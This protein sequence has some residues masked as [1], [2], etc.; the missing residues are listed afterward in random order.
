MIVGPVN[1]IHALHFLKELCPCRTMSIA[2]P[3]D[4]LDDL[5]LP[6][7]IEESWQPNSVC[8]AWTPHSSK[9]SQDSDA[10]ICD[11]ILTE[12]N[13]S[14]SRNPSSLISVSS[15]GWVPTQECRGKEDRTDSETRKR[16]LTTRPNHLDQSGRLSEVVHFFIE[17]YRNGISWVSETRTF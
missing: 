6:S 12:K 14:K 8:S 9:A 15:P 1:V 3:A 16:G 2:V 11:G 4:V 5:G 17:T 10:D 13:W 7:Y